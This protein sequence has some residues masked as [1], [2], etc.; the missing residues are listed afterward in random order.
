[1]CVRRT[2][3]LDY[4]GS[5]GSPDGFN[6]IPL[7]NSTDL[8]M[9]PSGS[10]IKME[11][12]QMQKSYKGVKSEKRCEVVTVWAAALHAAAKF[13]VTKLDPKWLP[14]RPMSSLSITEASPTLGG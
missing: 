3:Q 10:S 2:G 12:E 5:G 13:E 9:F 7:Y 1:M 11:K 14:L 8:T 6:S 4:I